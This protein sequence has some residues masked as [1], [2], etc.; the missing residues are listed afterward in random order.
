[1]AIEL[2]DIKNKFTATIKESRRITSDD[3]DEVRHIELT[4]DD[5]AFRYQEGQ[6]VAVLVPGPHPFGNPYHIRRYTIASSRPTTSAN[7][8]DFTIL[9]RRC[10]YIDP[11]NGEEYPGIAS[12]YLCD[13]GNGDE[14]ILAGPYAMPFTIPENRNANMIMVGAGTGIAPFRAFIEQIYQHHGG[15][16]G[17]VRLYYGAKTGLDLYYLNEADNDLTQYYTEETFKA[18]ASIASRPLS[19]DVDGLQKG[20]EKNSEEILEL[21]KD[22]NTHLFLCGLEKVGETF[23]QTLSQHLGSDEAWLGIRKQLLDS[24]RWNEMLYQ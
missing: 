3:T 16:K 23:E 13:L 7:K 6:S 9:V 10:F 1:M 4:V 12:N 18:V 14:V 17:Q 21:L 24:R 19:D 20:V 5:P 11:F 2:A 22:K 8:I 15:W